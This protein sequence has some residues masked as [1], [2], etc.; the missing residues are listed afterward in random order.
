M[1]VL[2]VAYNAL[3]KSVGAVFISDELTLAAE[4]KGGIHSS[5]MQDV[6]EAPLVSNWGVKSSAKNGA[7]VTPP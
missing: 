7:K 1:C 3:W 2:E 4:E 6:K 5:S